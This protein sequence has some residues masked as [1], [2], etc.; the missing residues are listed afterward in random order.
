MKTCV[1]SIFMLIASVAVYGQTRLA[2]IIIS[3]YV[4]DSCLQQTTDSLEIFFHQRYN[5]R[6]WHEGKIYPVRIEGNRFSVTIQPVS[7]ISWFQ[8]RKAV[9]STRLLK[10]IESDAFLV[11]AGDS[12]FMNFKTPNEVAVSGKGSEKINYQHFAGR[13]IS[14]WGAITYI[15][16]YKPEHIAYFKKLAADHLS[17]TMNE[18]DKIRPF[19]SGSVYHVLRYNTAAT[20]SSVYAGRIQSNIILNDFLVGDST[21]IELIKSELQIMD[22]QQRGFAATDPDVINH[23][24]AYTSYLADFAMLYS[25]VSQK[26]RNPPYASV[27]TKIINDYSGPLRDKILAHSIN[28]YYGV[29]TGP[30]FAT[31]A[32]DIVQ[33]PESRE[34]LTE[35]SKAKTSGAPAYD[36]SFEDVNGSKVSLQDLRGKVVVLEAW[37]N[38]CTGCTSL[39]ERMHPV[40]E[41]FRDKKNVVFLSLNVDRD[42]KRFLEGVKSGKYG[43][44]YSKYVYTN[45]KGWEHPMCLYYKWTSYPKMLIIDKEG[46]IITASTMDPVNEAKK[47]ELID[48]IARNM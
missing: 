30:E 43:S 13:L 34:L 25:Q 46:R 35:I 40:I 1:F 48:L 3:G 45:G 31:Q 4:P 27:Y 38:G 41:H 6:L 5:Q 22:L 20:I 17:R 26:K 7:E 21:Y 23:A 42:K 11:N 24:S 39:A 8:I 32:L 18:L 28:R 9:S 36:F 37:F 16:G 15:K 12:I 14:S 2:P 19:L 44:K 47:K 10:S 33:D 29:L